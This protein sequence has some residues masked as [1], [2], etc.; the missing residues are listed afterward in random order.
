MSLIPTSDFFSLALVLLLNKCEDNF[1]F[2]FTLTEQVERWSNTM[3]KSLRHAIP[4]IRGTIKG[5]DKSKGLS[6][7]LEKVKGQLKLK[8][9]NHFSAPADYSQ[10]D[11][12][13]LS[14]MPFS[15]P[16]DETTLPPFKPIERFRFNG[17]DFKVTDKEI[18][19]APSEFPESRFP[20]VTKSSPLCTDYKM[21]KGVN[22]DLFSIYMMK[23]SV[24]SKSLHK[25]K[26]FVFQYFHSTSFLG[27][28][29]KSRPGVLVTCH[30]SRVFNFDGQVRGKLPALIQNSSYPFKFAVYRTKL[31]KLLRKHFLEL[32]L[33]DTDFAERY[34]GLYKFSANLYPKTE[35]DVNDFVTNLKTCL[36]K[37]R[38]IDLDILEKQYELENSKMPW[39]DINKVLLRN[40]ITDFPIKPVHTGKKNPVIRNNTRR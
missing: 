19:S 8:Y 38:K 16:F 28:I 14:I 36:R 40:G 4:V 21:L 24:K 18:S 10:K 31:K 37:V 27:S 13:D 34:D 5:R 26:W 17:E 20:I 1:I 35:A 29:M 39:R 6:Q 7:A 15:K 12:I 9:E 30:N 22:S 32:Y 2:S 33:K 11:S 25:C 3:D 23:G